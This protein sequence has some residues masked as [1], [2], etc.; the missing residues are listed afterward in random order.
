MKEFNKWIVLISLTVLSSCQQSIAPEINQLLDAN[1]FEEASAILTEELKQNPKN[2]EAAI[3]SAKCNLLIGDQDFFNSFHRIDKLRR[4]ESNYFHRNNGDQMMTQMVI[5]LCIRAIK[6]KNIPLMERTLREP[7]FPAFQFND[8]QGFVQKSLELSEVLIQENKWEEAKLLLHRCYKMGQYNGVISNKLA[9]FMEHII[10]NQTDDEKMFQ[11]A[12]LFINVD[13]DQRKDIVP[14]LIRIKRSENSIPGS[15]YSYR[16]HG[17]KKAWL[18]PPKDVDYGLPHFSPIISYSFYDIKKEV[19]ESL[20]PEVFSR[21]VNSN[22]LFYNKQWRV[23]NFY[24]SL[25]PELYQD[26]L[27]LRKLDKYAIASSKDSMISKILRCKE[28]YIIPSIKYETSLFDITGNCF[29]WEDEYDINNQLLSVHMFIGPPEYDDDCSGKRFGNYVATI[30][31]PFSLEEARNFFKYETV[32]GKV[33]YRVYPGIERRG[34]GIAM[35]SMILKSNPVINISFADDTLT[36]AAREFVGEIWPKG[37][38]TRFWNR[39]YAM[40]PNSK[41]VRVMKGEIL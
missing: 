41:N 32:R 24:W 12:A 35:P 28:D 9:D 15:F 3:L 23:S 7:F 27:A 34:L 26:M 1:K 30:V 37:L 8:T 11:V 14:M 18:T 4:T 22:Y 20:S 6:E 10:R 36:I 16:E 21:C 25:I 2:L 39:N 5:S 29:A 40:K 33:S 13:P 17:D 31:V 38:E 19:I